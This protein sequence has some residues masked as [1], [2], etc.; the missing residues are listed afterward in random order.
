MRGRS[1][2]W[3]IPLQLAMD[4][5]RATALFIIVR[6]QHSATPLQSSGAFAFNE[7]LDGSDCAMMQASVVF[8]GAVSKVGLARS[9]F[10]FK[11]ALFTSVLDPVSTRI[12]RLGVPES[13]C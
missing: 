5:G 7:Q 13:T 4:P 10:D 8:G 1:T 11:L 12:S 3:G 9:P 6:I 2:E